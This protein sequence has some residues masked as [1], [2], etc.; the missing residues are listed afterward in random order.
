MNKQDLLNISN[1]NNG[2]ESDPRLGDTF[3]LWGK[4][5]A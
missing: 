1:V 3:A 2:V 4:V 5:L